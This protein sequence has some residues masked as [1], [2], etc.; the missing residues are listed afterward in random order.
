MKIILIISILLVI[1][2]I[3]SLF[4]L[5]VYLKKEFKGSIMIKINITKLIQFELKF[6]KKQ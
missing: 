5:R 6:T 2:V 3:S 4:F 1:S